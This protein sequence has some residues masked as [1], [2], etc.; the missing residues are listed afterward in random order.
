[1]N[2]LILITFA[3]ICLLL[4][5]SVLAFSKARSADN[6]RGTVKKHRVSVEKRK[7]VNGAKTQNRGSAGKAALKK[8]HKGNMIARNTHT[9]APTSEAGESDGEFIEYRVKKGDTVETVA[10]KF[11]IEREDILEANNNPGRRLSPGRVLLIPRKEDHET[12]DDFVDLSTRHLKPWKTNE[13]RYMLV[14]V[15]KSFM[16]A[17]YRYG[18][19]SLRG[20]DCSAFVKKVYD[21]F[22]A[23]LPRIARDQYKAGPRISR[24]E[25]SVG[26]LVFFKTKR[27][28]KYPTHVGIYIGEGNFIHS[29]SAH[30]RIG[31]TIDSLQTDFY[32]RAY[33]GATRVKQSS[34]EASSDTVSPQLL[35]TSLN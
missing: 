8:G 30:A 25:L 23:P 12:G 29:S 14:K 20:L 16:G 19:E 4:S 31:V 22:D 15:A 3:S 7:S 2:R 9:M 24:E 34:D 33:I 5:T 28:A 18:G 17:P 10:T 32:N 21:I 26:D 1:M 13:E 35:T 11:G 6:P 27:Y